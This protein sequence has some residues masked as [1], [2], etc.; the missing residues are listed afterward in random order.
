MDNIAQVHL[1]V[2]PG[3]AEGRHQAEMTTQLLYG[4]K[5]AI[6]E[7]RGEWLHVLSIQDDYLCWV[8]SNQVSG[9]I[10]E[11]NTIPICS[12]SR[13]YPMT[14]STLPYG[15]LVSI[16][17]GEAP[18]SIWEESMKWIGVPY[19]W[20]GRTCFGVDCSGLSQ[21]IMRSQGIFLPRDSWQQALEGAEVGFVEEC[22]EGDLAF[23]ADLEE[24]PVT[25][26]GILNGVGE[27]IHASGHVRKDKFDHQGIFNSEKGQYTHMLRT[28]RRVLI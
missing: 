9:E 21:L 3:R 27:I 4:E 1:P 8:R 20:G 11:N 25:H 19:L 28:I 15:S 22:R 13:Y 6:L 2:I 26:V 7:D 16:K 14:G 12:L 18:G 24:G 23:F 5:V 10:H 17:E